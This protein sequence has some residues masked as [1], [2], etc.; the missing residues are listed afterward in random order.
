MRSVLVTGGTGSFG[1]HIINRLLREPDITRVIVYSRDELKQF[2]MSQSLKDPRV[3]FFIGDVRDKDRLIMAG[4]GVDTIIHAAAMKQVLSSEYNPQECI[5][6]N[7]NGAENV[8]F[9]AIEN[10]V[11]K[12]LALSTDKAASPINLYGATKLV[13]DKLFVAANNLAG[14]LPT[15]FSVVRYGNVLGSRGSIVPLLLNKI[16]DNE[17]VF[18][19]THR[20]ATRFWIT[21]DQGVNFVSKS[22]QRMRGGEIFIPKLP[23]VRI[24][25]LVKS[26]GPHL[27]LKEIGLRPGEK[28]HEIMFSK[29]ESTSTYEFS[30]YYLIAPNILFRGDFK[31]YQ[32]SLDNE[33]GELLKQPFEYSSDKNKVFLTKQEID[34]LNIQNGFLK[35]P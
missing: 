28:L 33:N 32:N 23:S 18:P 2:E 30:E 31:D 22:I 26:L 25:D 21:L 9:S 16:N 13:S 1:K 20:E 7:I 34:Q 10:R 11:E 8:I 6:T 5:K 12:V 4:R 24:T 14:G 29:D 17:T 3:R 35:K 27:K 15:K 19:L